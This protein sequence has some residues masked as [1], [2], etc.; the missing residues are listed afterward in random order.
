MLL[1]MFACAPKT[2]EAPVATETPSA[3]ASKEAKNKLRWHMS[4]HFDKATAARDAVVKGDVGASNEALSWMGGHLEPVEGMDPNARP[5]LDA[6]HSTA[7]TAGAAKTPAEAGTGLGAVAESCARCHQSLQVTLSPV[8]ASLSPTADRSGGHLERASWM[9]GALWTGVIASADSA[10]SGGAE[11]L[12]KM[13]QDA[14]AWGVASP[15][16]GALAAAD[17]IN[18][19]MKTAVAAENRTTRAESF[20]KIV[21]AC[22]SCHAELPK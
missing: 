6:L 13:P 2:T 11:V 22:G 18:A 8:V 15:G 9:V 4:E 17:L 20:G 10:W 1:L 3:P 16:P 19:Q 14:G 21:G 7:Q 5:F 12:T